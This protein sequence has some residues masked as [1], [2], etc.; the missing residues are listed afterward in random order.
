[1]SENKKKRSGLFGRPQQSAG[2]PRAD[3]SEQAGVS[4]KKGRVG[5]TIGTIL[6]VMVLTIAIFTGIFMTWINTSL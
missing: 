1:M 6:L 5:R 4:R 3:V 2:Q